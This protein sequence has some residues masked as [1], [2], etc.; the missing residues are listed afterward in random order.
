MRSISKCKG[1]R[2]GTTTLFLA[3]ILTSV[4]FIQVTYFSLVVELDRKACFHRAVTTQAECFLA[5]YDRELFSVYGLYAFDINTL[6]CDV[7]H[8]VLTAN[9][10]DE[11]D[12]ITVSGID[13][14]DTEDLRAAISMYYATRSPGIVV[15][16]LIGCL[17]SYLDELDEMGFTKNIKKF[18]NS[19]AADVLKDIIEGAE[20]ITEILDNIT[21]YVDLFGIKDKVRSFKRFF[22][23][24][25]KVSDYVPDSGN[26]FDPSDLGFVIE[27]M[28]TAAD[29]YDSSSEFIDEYA[30]H[31]CLCHYAVYNFDSYLDEDVTINNTPVSEI[32]SGDEYDVEYII[33]G[34]KGD[35]AVD[36]LAVPM[37][38]ILFVREMVIT[39]TDKETIGVIEGIADVLSVLVSVVS[40][41]TVVL[42]PEVYKTVIAVLYSV[43]GTVSDVKDMYDGEKLSFLSV[44][45]HDV[46][47]LGYKDLLFLFM[48]FGDDDKILKRV[49]R[50]INRDYNGFAT[51]ITLCS[52]YK[53]DVYF[54]E[55]R[56]ELY[57]KG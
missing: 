20:N 43:I 2:H 45:G 6:D 54:Y 22:S 21:D 7:F 19:D 24:L 5:D 31:P 11:G 41:G 46:I 56:Y 34:K 1:R 35:D 14:F 51:G 4:I 36:T 8:N 52:M 48:L 40:V 38:A 12:V 55:R 10:I 15:S 28:E 53:G 30:F 49:T 3:I 25:R 9:G 44:K 29:L 57:E 50:V 37:F 39:Y 18:M 17:S 23:S 26:G 42:P 13:T 27:M 47:K 32:H 33:T 16:G